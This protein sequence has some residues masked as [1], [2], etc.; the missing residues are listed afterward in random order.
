[1]R[2]VSLLWLACA[3]LW[4][5]CAAAAW[6][7]AS[8][9]LRVERIAEGVYWMQGGS[10]ANTGVVIGRGEAAA[11]DAKTDAESARAMQ[12][13]IRKLTPNPVTTLI[14]THSDGDHVN[15]LA[16][17]PRGLRI[18]AHGNTRKDME[19]AFSD[20]KMGGLL[21]YLPNET[22]EG[23]QRLNIG[24]VRIELLHFGPAHT[25]GDLVV[26]LPEKKVVFL[27]DLAFIGRDP[28]IHR[29]KNGTSLGLVRTLKE[30]LALDAG[31]FIAGHAAPL[32]KA[33]L[34]GL[35][36]S[37]QE[38]QAKVRSLIQ[39][40]R[41]LEEVRTAFGAAPAPAAG[42]PRRPGFIEILY[43]DLGGK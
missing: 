13:E 5:A 15:G 18:V 1:M 16:G 23:S 32:K 26:Y 6:P 35:L 41:S 10:G 24:G 8:P 36:S 38:K 4:L 19:S 34:Q 43:Q 22:V 14:L 3:A 17:F 37:I 42:G 11:I 28:L 40:G 31:T 21:P 9:P 29:H 30:I 12:A 2:S 27:G 25:Q 33:D 20:P 39:Q 7:Q